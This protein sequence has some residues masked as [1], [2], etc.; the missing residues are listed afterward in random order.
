MLM[1]NTK[2]IKYDYFM[3]NCLRTYV[4]IMFL[5]ENFKVIHILLTVAIIYFVI[6]YFSTLEVV[7]MSIDYVFIIMSGIIY[8]GF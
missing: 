7:Y 5:K 3:F 6:K 1:N 8:I 2:N 4:Y